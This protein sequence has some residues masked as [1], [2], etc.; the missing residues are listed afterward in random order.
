MSKDN[1]KSNVANSNP[2]VCKEISLEEMEQQ[3]EK[4]YKS[5]NIDIE[6]LDVLLQN[7]SFEQK[8]IFL[9]K[10]S[11]YCRK[12]LSNKDV[13][14]IEQQYCQFVLSIVIKYKSKFI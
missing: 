7:Y 1:V 3:M 2:I 6:T 11:S 14:L 12:Q 13:T 10:L 9:D 8:N 5:F 4:A